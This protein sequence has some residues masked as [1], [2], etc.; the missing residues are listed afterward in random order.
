MGDRYVALIL[1]VDGVD[2]LVD[3]ALRLGSPILVVLVVRIATEFGHMERRSSE[4]AVG[5]HSTENLQ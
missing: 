3:S 1:R 2:D 5:R 4:G